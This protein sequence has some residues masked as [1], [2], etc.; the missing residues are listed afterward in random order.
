MSFIYL[1]FIVNI[2]IQREITEM[3]NQQSDLAIATQLEVLYWQSAQI[4]TTIIVPQKIK[5]DC[6]Q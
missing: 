1:L 6:A 2:Q 4:P 5:A 3:F